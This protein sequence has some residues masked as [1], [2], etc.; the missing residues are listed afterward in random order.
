MFFP[1]AFARLDLGDFNS[2]NYS[3]KFHVAR[4]FLL[5]KLRVSYVPATRHANYGCLTFI[6]TVTSAMKLNFVI[7]I[8]QTATTAKTLLFRT[9]LE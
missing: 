2:R 7:R 9:T 1:M 4:M 5:L 6:E 8:R 3:Y